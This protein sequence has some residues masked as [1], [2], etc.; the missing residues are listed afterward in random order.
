MGRRAGSS[1]CVWTKEEKINKKLQKVISRAPRALREQHPEK[2]YRLAVNGVGEVH[3]ATA[4]C[5]SWDHD[6]HPYD[7]N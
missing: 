2:R 1:H 5:S 6:A 4:S 3:G 7:A